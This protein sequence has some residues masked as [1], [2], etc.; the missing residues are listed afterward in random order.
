MTQPGEPTTTSPASPPVPVQVIGYASTGTINV[1][2]GGTR[3]LLGILGGLHFLIGAPLV[4]WTLAV[5][6]GNVSGSSVNLAEIIWIFVG[7]LIAAVDIACGVWFFLRRPWTWRAIHI[8]S[9]VMCALNLLVAGFAAGLIVYYKHAKGWDGIALAIGVIFFGACSIL[10]WLHAL[11]KLALLRLNVRRAYQLGDFEPHRLH[12]IGT[13]TMMG[14]YGLVVV[15]GLAA[16]V[17][18]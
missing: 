15:V 4:I 1:A 12:R 7:L 18:R 13:F 11:T 17:V 8:A 3:A 2:S 9:A 16:F 5:V 10:F 6:V 14:L